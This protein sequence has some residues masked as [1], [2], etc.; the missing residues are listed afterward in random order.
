MVETCPWKVGDKVQRKTDS[1]YVF[2]GIVIATG[3]KLDGKTWH[4]EV[5]CILPGV[6]GC[7]HV[8]PAKHLTAMDPIWDLF[9]AWSPST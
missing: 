5:E 6:T 1:S 8:F 4:C 2:P 3:L 7:T 9:A